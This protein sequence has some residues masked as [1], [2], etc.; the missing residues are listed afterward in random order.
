MKLPL[1]EPQKLAIVEHEFRFFSLS[2]QI[3]N[4][5]GDYET[6]KYSNDDNRPT[7][8]IHGEVKRLQHVSLLLNACPEL[9]VAE[10]GCVR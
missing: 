3:Y 7:T 5:V 1:N 4:H 10:G 2:L 9:Y 8:H 6:Q